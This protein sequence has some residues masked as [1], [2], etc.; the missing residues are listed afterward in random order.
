MNKSRVAKSDPSLCVV[1][2]NDYE[3]N[4]YLKCVLA[5][6]DDWSHKKKRKK[7]APHEE[8]SKEFI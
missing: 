3:I 7:S 8:I 1:R 4:I 6:S 2:W 5:P